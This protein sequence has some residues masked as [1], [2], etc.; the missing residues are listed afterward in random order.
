MA[1]KGMS[2]L[3][4]VMQRDADFLVKIA[5]VFTVII[6]VLTLIFLNSVIETV[7]LAGLKT[8]ADNWIILTISW[9][10]LALFARYANSL[11]ADAKNTKPLWG[12]FIIGLLFAATGR[13]ESGILVVLASILYFYSHRA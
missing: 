2:H 8:T 9:L 3:K 11:C 13:I 4:R 12:L 5:I 10:F 6:S 7:A 1:K